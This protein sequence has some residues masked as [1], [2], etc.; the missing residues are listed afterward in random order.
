M[1][2]TQVKTTALSAIS[3]PLTSTTLIEA[4]AGT[5]KTFTMASLYL[6]LLIG[7]G[8]NNFSRPLTV[9]EILVVTFTDASTQELKARIR[10]RIQ[11]AKAQFI[12][13][14]ENRDL[15]IFRHTDNAFLITQNEQETS[16]YLDK[17]DLKETIQRLQF[18]EQNMDLAAIYTI[19]G[20]CR[21]MLMQY[22]VNSGIHFNL[23]LVK[24]EKSLLTKLTNEF[25]REYFYSRS[26][27]VTQF[28][29]KHLQS[30]ANLLARV[31]SYLTGK[32]FKVDQNQP[33]L[34][35][36]SLTEFLETNIASNQEKL[37]SFLQALKEQWQV[38]FP[39]FSLLF[40]NEFEKGNAMGLNGGKFRKGF[41]ES[42]V[43]QIENWVNDLQLNM[44]PDALWFFTQ[45]YLNGSFK[46]GN[47]PFQHSFFHWLDEQK[48]L[49]S[50]VSE[51]DLLYQNV[52]L[53]HCVR[54]LNRRL[55]EYKQ[56][57]PEKGFN[58][59]LRLLN[60]ALHAVH[61]EQLAE[62]IRQQYPFAM[63]D[64]F[65]DTDEEQYQ[66]FSR[67]YV[68][69][70]DCGF[71]MIGDP[72]QAIYQFR[73]AD[74]FTYLKAAEDAKEQ[75]FTLN[76]NYRSTPELIHAV[77]QLLDFDQVF[78][79]EKIQFETVEAGRNQPRFELNGKVQAPLQFYINREETVT[80]DD[81][82]ECCANSI[83]HWLQSAEKNQAVFV[84]DEEVRAVQS[85][86]IAVLVRT[87]AQAEKIQNALRKKGI[88]SVY[89]SDRSNVFNT[90]EAR[91]LAIVLT[92]C[93]YPTNERYI[94]NAISTGLF[95]LTA[96]EIQQ[97]KQSEALLEQ[98]VSRFE[99]YHQLW[100]RQG[101]LP[102]I[103]QCLLAQDS[104]LEKQN[105]PE[106]MLALPKGERRLTDVLHLAELLQQ[107]A[108]LQESESALLRWFERQIKGANIDDE[109]DGTQVRLESEQ[110][111]VKIVTVHKSKGLEYGLVWLPFLGYN[112][113]DHARE[114]TTYHNEQGEKYWD[115]DGEH[116]VEAD[117]EEF[118][119][120]MRLLYVALTRAK[121]QLS[122]VVPT[123]FNERWN[124][125]L[126]SLTQGQIGTLKRIGGK[127]KGCA[128]VDELKT[129][130]GDAYC[131]I[132]EFNVE[133][134][135]NKWGDSNQQ[136]TYFAAEFSGQIE[137]NWGMTSFSGLTQMHERQLYRLREQATANSGFIDEARDYDRDSAI[138]TDAELCSSLHWQ[139]FPVERTP[140][141]FPAGAKFGVMIHGF[142]EK[143]D[144]R[145]GVSDESAVQICRALQLDESWQEPLKN[146][147]QQV[148]NAPLGLGFCL[149][150][151]S[152]QDCLKEWQF[153]LKFHRTFDVKAFNHALREFHPL[154]EQPY[155]FDE[156]QGMLRGFVD[157]VFRHEGKY[158][159]L[160]Y[161]TNHL[162]EQSENYQQEALAQTM[163]LQHY[164][165]QY[166][167]YTL[168]LHH[169]LQLRDA[170]YDYETHFGGVIYTFIRGMNGQ[171]ENGVYFDR[172]D[173]RLIQA[174][175]ALFHA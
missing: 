45:S 117:K 77:N 4:S 13:Y 136:P 30:P 41:Y 170:D 147:L 27:L 114:V 128:L 157:L 52:L 19:H 1:S 92:A 104:E 87:G 66:I 80:I 139:D 126:Y 49:V 76:K 101:V 81:M 46:K 43:A 65:Q 82:A 14:Q 68:N 83:L 36:I 94:L 50:E 146:W 25:W 10:Q 44:P 124:P 16:V 53:Y 96:E 106:K 11:Q 105:L 125:L 15:A 172:P 122:F 20:F 138:I 57:H 144:F 148:L 167:F 8:E 73:G 54:E 145:Q 70:P 42:R 132:A 71:M 154:F 79:N 59:L 100:Q 64:E 134:S 2:K 75:R 33:H 97:I 143:N 137:Q 107:A 40:L 24:D 93:L 109:I 123:E 119:E 85:D 160:D 55:I 174:L 163:K 29:A 38:N 86:D 90:T 95:A 56:N 129:R 5:G 158:Y 118:A 151:L 23:E 69:Q 161:K 39:E 3:T 120:E 6:R 32:N 31:Q 37:A 18:A 155:L 135:E 153:F 51:Q 130:L 98:W 12:A 159:L 67:I 162:G 84:K 152:P 115:L 110:K 47:E 149:G 171:A 61:G 133:N 113:K 72:K 164:D 141:H 28:I 21:R 116:G 99:H 103:Y 22:A 166:L 169:Y 102:M 140:F 48:A 173:V 78:I 74:I 60:E 88:A 142:F 175:G 165:L 63:I 168:A 127:Q 150:D 121:Y 131:Q 91:E 35:N 111:L 9:D 17:L 34:L 7:V 112:G 62:F 58:D 108:A 156:I 89:L 26:L